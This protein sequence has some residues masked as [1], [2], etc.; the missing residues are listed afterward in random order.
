MVA[1][2]VH[3]VYTIPLRQNHSL[4]G[5]EIYRRVQRLHVMSCLARYHPLYN[6][7]F[8]SIIHP[9]LKVGL[10]YQTR[11]PTQLQLPHPSAWQ[12]SSPPL[13]PPP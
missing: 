6:I 1:N 8:T 12:S 13:L 3:T 5:V 11:P 4:F 10:F 9:I 2:I 7:Y